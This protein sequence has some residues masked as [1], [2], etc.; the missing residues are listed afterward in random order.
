MEKY[1]KCKH[2]NPYTEDIRENI[3]T[4]NKL[5]K[6]FMLVHNDICDQLILWRDAHRTHLNL[7]EQLLNDKM[8]MYKEE[9]PNG[10]KIIENQIAKSEGDSIKR[11]KI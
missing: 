5:L 8:S 3:R 1:K 6:D 7:K 9:T 11:T 2:Q 4:H 10:D